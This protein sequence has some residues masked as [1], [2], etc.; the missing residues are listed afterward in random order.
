M[1]HKQLNSWSS[2]LQDS[3]FNCFTAKWKGSQN[4]LCKLAQETQ[5]FL[6]LYVPA[7]FAKGVYTSFR[8]KYVIDYSIKSDCGTQGPG[9]QE[10]LE[11][12]WSNATKISLANRT[13]E[14]L[15]FL[16]PS[17]HDISEWWL[18]LNEYKLLLKWRAYI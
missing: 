5:T 11:V 13:N 8:W 16:S 12:K 6:L 2:L 9:K 17:I 10:Q 4:F 18:R 1:L 7:L 15:G 14:K 3:Y